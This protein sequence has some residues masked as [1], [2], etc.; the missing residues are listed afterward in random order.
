MRFR[1]VVQPDGRSILTTTEQLSQ[2]DAIRLR[3]L[4]DQWLKSP[5]NRALIV[6]E[7]DVVHIRTIELDLEVKDAACAEAPQPAPAS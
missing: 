6:A 5:D 4:W 1:L 7:C 3:E 2:D